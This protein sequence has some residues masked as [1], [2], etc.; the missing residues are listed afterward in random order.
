MAHFKVRLIPRPEIPIAAAGAL[1]RF[2]AARVLDR[3]PYVC[4]H[5]P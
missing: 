4:Y 1:L 2:R 3:P 5:T